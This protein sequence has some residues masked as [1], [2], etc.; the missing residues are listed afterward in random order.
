[1][2]AIKKVWNL[3]G[4]EDK[5]WLES[6]L[7]RFLREKDNVFHILC[8]TG[9]TH[10]TKYLSLGQNLGPSYFLSLFLFRFWNR[11]VKSRNFAVPARFRVRV[12]RNIASLI[13]LGAWRCSG[14]FPISP[15]LKSTQMLNETKLGN[16]RNFLR[17]QG[18]GNFRIF[19]YFHWLGRIPRIV[20]L[21][22][23]R[24]GNSSWFCR[25]VFQVKLE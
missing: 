20:Q 15:C 18:L 22:G 17:F 23:H 9:Q 2:Y 10:L 7:L 3:K 21:R 24:F 8:D 5:N 12:W 6:I 13:V 25:D 1:M 19:V 11:F 4:P 16:V 14:P